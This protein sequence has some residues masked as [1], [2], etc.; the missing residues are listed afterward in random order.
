MPT[1]NLTKDEAEYLFW[2]MVSE[3]RDG[4]EMASRILD[5]LPVPKKEMTE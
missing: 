5:K 2:L 4:N 1:L 3:E